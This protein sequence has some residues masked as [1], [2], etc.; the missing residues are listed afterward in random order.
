EAVDVECSPLPYESLYLL[1]T[2]L[3]TYFV[4][5][6][7]YNDVNIYV[8][9][10]DLIAAQQLK[11]F[12]A[13]P[14]KEPYSNAAAIA[15]HERFSEW[16]WTI[17]ED[18]APSQHS[19]FS[20]AHS[21]IKPMQQ[22]GRISH[23]LCF[24]VTLL[25]AAAEQRSPGNGGQEI[26]TRLPELYAESYYRNFPHDSVGG[27]LCADSTTRHWFLHL[28]NVQEAQESQYRA[29]F[30]YLVST[31]GSEELTSSELT[32]RLEAGVAYWLG[33][34]CTGRGLHPASRTAPWQA[35]DEWINGHATFIQRDEHDRFHFFDPNLGS[36]R[37][38]TEDEVIRHMNL[39]LSLNCVGD[40]IQ[41]YGWRYAAAINTFKAGTTS[42]DDFSAKMLSILADERP[43]RKIWYENGTRIEIEYV[44]HCQEN[45]TRCISA[46]VTVDRWF[47]WTA[48]VSPHDDARAAGLR[49]YD[50]WREL[51]AATT[52]SSSLLHQSDAETPPDM[53]LLAFLDEFDGTTAFDDMPSCS[54]YDGTSDDT[55]AIVEFLENGECSGVDQPSASKANTF[56]LDMAR[57]A[58]LFYD[59]RF[60]D[61]A[62]LFET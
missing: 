22:T 17:A 24:G 28:Q 26:L 50:A 8:P 3:C 55:Y 6:G 36:Y 27:M 33:S 23:G 35:L 32:R 30:D 53:N 29:S 47:T 19:S 62:G 39:S 59:D 41:S 40:D 5:R 52:N 54:T 61:E 7:Q 9:A 1:L 45:N 2:R 56:L 13:L 31:C 57:D 43:V 20:Q 51:Q 25:Y 60:A 15:W 34:Y 12:A 11:I 16:V 58:D 21:L 42:W 10:I 4:S 38:Q 18:L 49:A 44:A 37:H 48:N 46:T 14:L